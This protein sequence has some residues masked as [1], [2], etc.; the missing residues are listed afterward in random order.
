MSVSKTRYNM[1][2]VLGFTWVLQRQ[3]VLWER[4]STGGARVLG[5]QNQEEDIPTGLVLRGSMILEFRRL[6]T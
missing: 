1:R 3:S 4:K 6:L 5:N 2:G